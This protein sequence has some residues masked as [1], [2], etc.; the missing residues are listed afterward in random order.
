MS[1][2]R[3]TSP[4]SWITLLHAQWDTLTENYVRSGQPMLFTI[5]LFCVPTPNIQVAQAQRSAQEVTQ[6]QSLTVIRNLMRTSMSV[7]CYLRNLFP[8]VG[9]P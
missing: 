3:R 9:S 6:Q 5:G 1:A 8:E 7:V 4:L 2:V